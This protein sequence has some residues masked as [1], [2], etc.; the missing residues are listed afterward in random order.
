[1]CNTI[2]INRK[3]EEVLSSDYCMQRRS[4]RISVS[5]TLIVNCLV[6]FAAKRSGMEISV[7]VMTCVAELAFKYTS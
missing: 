1:M 7:P 3:N 6:C 4:F 5:L 2:R